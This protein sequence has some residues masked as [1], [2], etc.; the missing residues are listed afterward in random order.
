MYKWV[1]RS[2]GQASGSNAQGW[3]RS[4]ALRTRKQGERLQPVRPRINRHR[5]HQVAGLKRMLLTEVWFMGT[6]SIYPT[7]DEINSLPSKVKRYIH[8][9]EMRIDQKGQA[10]TVMQLCE[11]LDLLHQRV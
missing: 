3:R 4:A 11:E 2:P 9:L 6:K 8:D 1:L 7:A 5:S 10:L